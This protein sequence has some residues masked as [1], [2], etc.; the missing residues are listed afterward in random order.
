MTHVPYFSPKSLRFLQELD[1]NNNR[2]WFAA[3]R[4]DYRVH[5]AE[6][7]KRLARALT[8]MVRELDPQI[9]TDPKRIVSRIYRDTRFSHDKS[10]YRPRVWIAFK[11][12]LDCWSE[13]PVYFFQLEEKEYMFGM[14][15]Y[16]ASSATMRRFRGMIDADPE[17]FSEAIA[18]LRKNKAFRLESERYKRPLPCP[19][20]KSIEPW[21]QSKSIGVLCRREPDN[22][23]FSP[24]FA[25]DLIER[26]IPLKSL[27]DYLWSATV[28]K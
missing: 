13:T 22:K 19:H 26:F 9:M 20:S 14:G 2:E 25:D 11:R 28:L 21:Y 16:A 27:Y 1:R 24:K 4:D 6:P 5:V 7:M 3:H 23:L 12:D 18:F 15:M 17:R 10:P 8:P